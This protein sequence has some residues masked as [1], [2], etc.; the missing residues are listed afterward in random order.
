MREAIDDNTRVICDVGSVYM[1]FA[2]NFLCYKPHHLLFSNGQQTL[3]V[4]LPWAMGALFADPASKVVLVS[5]DGGFLFSAMELETAVR[6]KC[7][8]IHFIWEDQRYDMVYQQELMKYQ[9]GSG[10]DFGALN[11]P[12]FTQGFGAK[13]FNLENADDFQTLFKEAQSVSGPVL[14]NVSIDYSDNKKMF[15]ITHQEVGN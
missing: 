3:G 13:G 11:I 1:W 4:S 7:N 15:E 6:E 10:V 14:I 2:R 8:F 9:R 5:G 12:A